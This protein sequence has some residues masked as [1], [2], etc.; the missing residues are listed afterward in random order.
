MGPTIDIV[1]IDDHAL[2]A[3]GVQLL[4]NAAGDPR[5]RVVATTDAPHRAAELVRGYAATVALVDLAMPDPGGLAVVA[6][7]RRR[8]PHLRILVL[9]G[10]EGLEAPLTALAAG[11]DGFLPKSSD[12]EA[13]VQPLLSVAEGWQVMS[14]ELLRELVSRARRPATTGIPALTADEQQLWRRVAAGASSDELARERHVS[15]RSAKRQVAG[16]LRK[17]GVGSR[18]EAAALA[19]RCGLLDDATDESVAVGDRR[20]PPATR[21]GEASRWHGRTPVG[22]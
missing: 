6:D 9:S 10:V 12:P 15:E 5:V 17:L 14:A 20:G 13:L 3:R 21:P 11:A 16:L 19:G 8:F 7:L 18:I 2:F 22:A 4:L 1:V